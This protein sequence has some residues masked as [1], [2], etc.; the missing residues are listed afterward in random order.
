[1][2]LFYIISIASV[3]YI[4]PA[5]GRVFNRSQSLVFNETDRTVVTSMFKNFVLK[6]NKAY[7]NNPE[8][9]IWRQSVFKQSLVRHAKLNARELELNGTAV[10]GINQFS[11][12]TPEEFREFLKRGVQED[13]VS[14]TKNAMTPSGCC[15]PKLNSSNTPPNRDWRKDGK[16]S[17]VNN[18]GKC[19]SCWA[20]TA[21]EC[22]ESQWAIHYEH[23]TIKDLS[24]QELISC[25]PS[26]G[27]SGGNTL[28]ALEWLQT[29]NYTLAPASEF[30]YVDK[31]TTCRED[32]LTEKGVRIKCGCAVQI[33]EENT[34]MKDLVGQHG[35]LAVNVDATMWHDYFGGII[36][37]HCTDTD[38][39]HA[40]QIVGYDFNGHIWYWIVRN[41]WGKDYGEQGYLKIKMGDNL[42]G[43]ADTPSFVV[44]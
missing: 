3:F 13:H 8:E 24:V 38:I 35:P 7:L 30:P 22:V 28:A 23:Q 19:G 32:L 31:E 37:H 29:K 42:C 14:F 43:V 27:C 10:Y 36:Q 6:F 18:Q 26:Q 5:Q 4:L 16:V 15:T 9:Y 39:N 11:D 34:R 21:T 33:K 40:V 41:S 25:S 2:P 12:W 44:I 1:M 17:A 20:F